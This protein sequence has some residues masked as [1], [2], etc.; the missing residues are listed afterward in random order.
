MMSF[1][2]A[3]SPF[4]NK[5]LVSIAGL[6]AWILF[7]CTQEY[8]VGSQISSLFSSYKH[9]LPTFIAIF[10]VLSL[11]LLIASVR[12]VLPIHSRIYLSLSW[13]LLSIVVL[14][15]LSVTTVVKGLIG[16]NVIF[17][18]ARLLDS[19][20]PQAFLDFRTGAI[21]VQREIKRI[22]WP[23]YAETLKFVGVVG[24]FVT[25]SSLFWWIIDGVITRVLSFLLHVL[26]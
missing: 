4:Q 10:G 14:W 3:N 15:A 8:I 7:F 1:S 20:G 13:M 22:H 2:A 5:W 12:A 19:I 26:S 17:L 6:C 25:V 21:E 24:A 16:V 23:S 11:D 9:F 18:S